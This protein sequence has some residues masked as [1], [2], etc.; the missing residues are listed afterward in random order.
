MQLQLQTGPEQ[1][2]GSWQKEPGSPPLQLQLN[3]LQLQLLFP[4]PEQLQLQNPPF[5]QLQF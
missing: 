3:P 5:E 1:N 4:S 2:E